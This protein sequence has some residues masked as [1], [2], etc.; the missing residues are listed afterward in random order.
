MKIITG[1]CK[2]RKLLTDETGK[3]RPTT[4]KMKEAIFSILNHKY[5]SECIGKNI[6]DLC[7]VSGSLGLESLSRGA[8]FRCF[9][10]SSLNSVKFIKSNIS[11]C[12]F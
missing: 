3:V 2:G 5:D 4:M 7:A 12:K 8:D 11:R 6:L 10:D 1:K 9:I